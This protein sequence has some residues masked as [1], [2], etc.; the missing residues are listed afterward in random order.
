[1]SVTPPSSVCM[2]CFVISY[3]SSCLHTGLIAESVLERR[4]DAVESVVS[5]SRKG[6]VRGMSSLGKK[7]VAR[8]AC[9]RIHH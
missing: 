4:L 5:M 1:M 6:E 9:L 2:G 7:V 3:M 8:E